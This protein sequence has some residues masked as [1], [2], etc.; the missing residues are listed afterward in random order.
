MLYDER[1]WTV[2]NELA[3]GEG[4]EESRTLK[5]LLAANTLA[6]AEER[7][8]R[9]ARERE[10]MQLMKRPIE[11]R[12]ALSRFGFTIGALPSS[13]VF[14][15]LFTPYSEGFADGGAALFFVLM[16]A[17]MLAMC[18]WIG[19]TLGAQLSAP[20]LRVERQSWLRMFVATLLMG[21]FW[22]L[23]T[24]GAGG[25]LF[26]GVGAPFGAICAA[27]IGGV[28]F[29]IFAF[30]HRILSRGGMIEAGHLWPVSI[31]IALIISGFILNL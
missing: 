3:R 14:Y 24:G 6:A 26:F 12:K 28:A 29:P 23:C 27:I 19:S 9:S 13:A 30:F 25:A 2:R 11:A 15:K 31:A 10:E 20:L 4:S 22:G 18:I 1:R 16:S 7:L 21:V 5:W 17:A 8:F